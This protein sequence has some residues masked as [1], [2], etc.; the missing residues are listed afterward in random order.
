MK[1]IL[2]LLAGIMLML[3]ACS[4][5]GTGNSQAAE[6]AQDQTAAHQATSAAAA[7]NSVETMSVTTAA[8]DVPSAEDLRISQRQPQHTENSMNYFVFQ[9]DEIIHTDD[10][11]RQLLI[12]QLTVADFRSLDSELDSWVNGILDGI[13][14]SDI[15]FGKDLLTYAQRD[16]KALGEA[17]F[18]AYSHYVSMGVG[19]HDDAV[20]SVLYLSSAYSG[21]ANP[22]SVQMAYNLDLNQK[23]VLTLEDVVYEDGTSALA[24]MVQSVVENKF[25]A[26][27]EGALFDNYTETVT[28]AFTYGNM[29]PYWYFN[30]N[31]LVIFFN[32]YELGPYAAG[33]IK[34]QLAYDQLDG[35]LRDSYFPAGYTGTV[36]DISLLQAPEEGEWV[37]YVDLGA[38]DTYYISIEGKASHV[39]LSEVFYVEKTLVGESMLFS[40]NQLDD[41]TTIALTV[42]LSDSSRTY[43]VEY[44]D[45]NG[46]PYVIYLQG[47][48]IMTQLP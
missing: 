7:A 14:A 18:Y 17:Q 29:T 40:A 12:E 36:T 13:Y 32:Q 30:D 39:Q 38:G 3:S 4:S 44:F 22:N 35:I 8:Q 15:Q 9:Q 46:G 19:R 25:A 6:I 34:A 27:G 21:G 37:Y 20:A 45:K 16:L 42:D 26:L 47:M 48:N 5:G 41:T 10:E 1:K 43:A 31:G 28:N 33:I 2:L 11:N 23:K 24:K